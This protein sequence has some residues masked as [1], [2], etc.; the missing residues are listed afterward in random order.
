MVGNIVAAALVLL[1]GAA[2]LRTLHGPAQARGRQ[3]WRV[4]T[5]CLIMGPVIAAMWYAVEYVAGSHI[6]SDIPEELPPILLIG[7]IAGGVTA[8]AAWLLAK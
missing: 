1:M 4:A 7:T 3:V 6:P 5:A 8:L 2:V